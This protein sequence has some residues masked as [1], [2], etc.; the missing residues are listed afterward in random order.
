[1]KRALRA[2]FALSLAPSAVLAAPV[3]LAPHAATYALT[4]ERAQPRSGIVAAGGEITLRFE[5]GACTGYAITSRLRLDLTLRRQGERRLEWRA[6]SWAAADGASFD[7]MERE[8][9]NGRVGKAYRLR[10]ARPAPDGPARVRFVKPRGKPVRQPLPAGTLLPHETMQRLIA[11]GRAGKGHLSFHAFEGFDDGMARRVSAVIA[12]VKEDAAT[13][14]AA[15]PLAGLRSWWV[16]LAY[17]PPAAK[18]GDD[19]AGFGVPEFEVGYRL[20]E[21]GVITN[22]RLIYA[23]YSLKGRLTK[24]DMLK[25]SSDCR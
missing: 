4:L 5:G 17:Y 18:K 14:R 22:L 3:E 16:A 25:A 7:Y 1:M 21:N 24:L 2:L 8:L 19:R 9:I 15:R 12:P 13:T 20:Y 11:A 10:F 6:Q 23:R